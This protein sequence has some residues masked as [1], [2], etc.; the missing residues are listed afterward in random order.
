MDG[1]E[2]PWELAL[3]AFP[4]AGGGVEF[5]VWAPRASALALR[6]GG[7]DH[8]LTAIGHG[9]YERHLPDAA[10]GDDYVY[11]V[12][13][14]ALP[15]PSSRWQPAGIR[16]PSRVV[17]A[18]ALRWSAGGWPGLALGELVIYELHIGAFSEAG[19][20][21]G[22]IP[23]LRALRELGVTA[24]ELMPIAEWPGQRGWGY[25][26]VYL[27]APFGPYGGPAGLA[28]LVDAAHA[29]GLGVIL[30]VVYNHLGASGMKAVEAFGPYH[31]DRHETFWGVGLNYD[32]PDCDPVREWVIQSACQWVGDYR[33][34]G[35]RL[36]AVH[37]ILDS[38][39]RHLLAQLAERV[40]AVNPQAL[41]I[42]ESALNDPRVIRPVELGGYG[43]DAQWAD[44]F[45]HALRVLL[46]GDRDGYYADFGRIAD[47]AKAYIRPFVHDG[48][49]SEL[50][51]RRFGAP[52]LD[53]AP[54]Q[55][56]VFS[57]NHDQVGNRAFGDRLPDDARRLAAFCTL[58][59]PF[60]PLLFMG[61][62][63]GEPR[64][65]QFF[66]DHIDAEIAT[67]TREGRRREF[68]SF[69][70]FD[71]ELPDP[72][73]E[74]TFQTSKLS[75]EEDPGLRALYASL[76]QLRSELVGREVRTAFDEDARSLRVGRDGVELVCNF[77]RSESRIAIEGSEIVLATASAELTDGHLS[78]PALSGAVVR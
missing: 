39:A 24:I 41:V 52:A 18:G 47:L 1:A 5:R 31:S 28:A 21:E 42:A 58:L 35:L 22:A 11:L 34:D 12:D 25:D 43:T 4:L 20:F 78:L 69:A 65:F 75:R 40:R 64:P 66:S 9:V 10:A 77:A 56:V 3:G 29:E 23:H 51:R 45:H 54:E 26:G 38:S 37:A 74:L 44:D 36:D 72:Q 50:R 27:S 32:G 68:A 49:Y 76:L 19:T 46:T 62:E 73:A 59:S 14:Q 13:G 70:S 17:D 63:Y 61:E 60:T 8:E 30:D 53:R 33:I 15:D 55:F 2:Y 7:R 67:A 57:Q 71:R 6:T 16:G 48:D